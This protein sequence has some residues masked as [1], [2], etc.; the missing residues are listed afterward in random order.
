[1]ILINESIT[2]VAFPE[3]RAARF[4]LDT[5]LQY[6]TDQKAIIKTKKIK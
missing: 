5:T 3:N 6:I 2:S 4:F 1:M